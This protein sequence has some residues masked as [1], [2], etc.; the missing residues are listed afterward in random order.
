MDKL[1]WNHVNPATGPVYIEGA[2]P[3]DV[4]RVDLLKVDVGKQASMGCIR[5]VHDDVVAI[6]DMLSEGRSTVLVTK[7]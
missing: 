6:F 1:D 5:L 4:L 3:G 2:K 7:D